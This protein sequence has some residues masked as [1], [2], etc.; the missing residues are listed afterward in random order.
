MF[1]KPHF[2]LFPDTSE[3]MNVVVIFECEEL[4]WYSVWCKEEMEA[5]QLV[6]R[7]DEDPS[8]AAVLLLCVSETA[9]ATIQCDLHKLGVKQ[10]GST[11][12]GESTGRFLV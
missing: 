4:R 6:L 5:Q 11:N 12:T 9:A 3:C 7:G 10:D 2:L 1:R 8:P